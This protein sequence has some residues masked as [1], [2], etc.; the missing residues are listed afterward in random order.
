MLLRLGDEPGAFFVDL[1]GDGQL[2]LLLLSFGLSL[3]LA[4][5]EFEAPSLF[6]ILRLI[7]HLVLGDL[8]ST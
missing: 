4:H 1:S 2:Q 3:P 7:L 6:E 5:R 8:F